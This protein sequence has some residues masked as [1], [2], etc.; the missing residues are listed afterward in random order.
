[1]GLMRRDLRQV[2]TRLGALP[3]AGKVALA[4]PVLAM[5]LFGAYGTTKVNSY[6]QEDPLFCASCHQP[7]EAW[8]RWQA[9][10][11]NKVTCRSC[12][13]E[14]LLAST[15][16]LLKSKVRATIELPKH[17]EV[18]S[19]SCSRCH[20]SS[21]PQWIQVAA[22]SGHKSHVEQGK[23][24][25]LVCHGQSLHRTIPPIQICTQCHG[26]RQIRIPAMAQHNCLDCHNFLREN[27]PLRPDRDG[28]LDCHQRQGQDRISWPTDAPM[29]FECR[30]CHQPHVQEKPVVQCLSCHPSV[31]GEGQHAAR[32]HLD[33]S[34][35]SCHKPHEWRI[36]RR[37]SCTS[38]H[39][40]RE[41]HN[42]GVFC[43]TCHSFKRDG[44]APGE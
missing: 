13:D 6:V 16:L 35:Q 8:S 40:D 28:C 34:C 17:G 2:L 42:P 43:G 22:T 1:M 19:E 5:F 24:S 38:C 14:G 4:I 27:S 31:N 26:E 21:D 41:N 7:G 37:Q 10:E 36:T 9:S 39:S 12:H 44:T 32:G 29:K 3:T 18:S 15:E 33:L 30:Q 25:C 20:E 23:L 11:H